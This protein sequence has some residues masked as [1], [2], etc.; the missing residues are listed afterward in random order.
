M[1]KST[2]KELQ[3]KAA[4]NARP[5]V[6]AKRVLNNKARRQAIREG[7]AHVGDGKDIDHIKPLENGG[8][9]AES[10]LRV[11]T[12]KKNRGW[13]RGKSGYNP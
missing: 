4:Y 12:Q 8:S 6:M 7:K 3:T 13:R 2:K 10:N 9:N 11:T 1:T 5:E